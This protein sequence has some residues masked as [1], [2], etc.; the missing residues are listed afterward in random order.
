MR[1]S[2]SSGPGS[3]YSGH[4]MSSAETSVYVDRDPRVDVALVRSVVADVIEHAG[5]VGAT[6]RA[7]DVVCDN[8]LAAPGSD[9]SVDLLQ[10]PEPILTKLATAIRDALQ[11]TLGVR[12]RLESEIPELAG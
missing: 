2:S 5:I 12:A 4:V 7:W 11:H 3:R 8:G 6:Y 10:L 9:V 1:F